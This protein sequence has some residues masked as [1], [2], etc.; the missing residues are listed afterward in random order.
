[1]ARWHAATAMC[2]F[3]TACWVVWSPQ[4]LGPL[5]QLMAG[6]KLPGGQYTL[7]LSRGIHHAAF[8][9]LQSCDPK[10]PQQQYRAPKAPKGRGAKP[11]TPE[12]VAPSGEVLIAAYGSFSNIMYSKY[13]RQVGVPPTF[14]R[15]PPRAG[16]IRFDFY[17]P[18]HP[19][20]K[21]VAGNEID[22]AH[23]ARIAVESGVAVG[24]HGMYVR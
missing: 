2:T 6:S 24:W 7:N 8:Q 18:V 10:L 20:D 3:L 12:V 14:F 5:F 15:R 19:E 16:T 23:L 4:A 13:P 11:P 9:V 17:P 21:P 1:M 22:M